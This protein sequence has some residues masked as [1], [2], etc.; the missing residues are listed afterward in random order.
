MRMLAF[1]GRNRKEI[2]RDPLS[3]VFG[4]GFPVALLGMMTMMQH[5]LNAPVVVFGLDVF[6]PGMAVF[7]LSFISLFLGMLVAGDRSSSF[8]MR[9]FASPLTG[10]EYIL[11][12]S[13]PMVPVAIAQSTICFGTAVALGLPFTPRMFVAILALIP[14][15]VLFIGFGLL[16]GSNLAASQVGGIASI[17]VNVSTLLSGTWFPDVYKRQEPSRPKAALNPLPS[18]GAFMISSSPKTVSAPAALRRRLVRARVW[19][20]Q[21]RTWGV[22]SKMVFAPL[23]KMNS[24][25]APSS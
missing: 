5:S 21:Q 15:G 10:A 23:A 14:V 6:T 24:T 17:L 3:L 18:T 13:L 16:I 8:L 1:A 22:Y 4:V 9:L 20:S 7:G 2:L 19:I 11:G 25:S 12:Y